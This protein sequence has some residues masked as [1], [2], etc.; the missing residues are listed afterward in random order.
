MRIPAAIRTVPTSIFFAVVLVVFEG[1]IVRRYNF[2]CILRYLAWYQVCVLL[3][4][5]P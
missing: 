1:L 3:L 2:D 4:F 5:S